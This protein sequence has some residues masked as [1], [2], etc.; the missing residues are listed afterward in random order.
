MTYLNLL[1]YKYS[2]I[3]ILLSILCLICFFLTLNILP[4]LDRDESRYIQSTV[5]MLES[6]D[7]V[8][9]NFLETP[10]LKKPPGVYW[11]QA[12]SATFIKNIF[13]LESPPLWSFRLPSAIG[14]GISV[15]LTFLLGQLLFSRAQGFLA[16]LLLV[17]S[18]L[19]IIESHIAKTDSALLAFFLFS[20]YILAK[21]IFYLEKKIKRPSD[22]TI[23][24]AWAALAFS[25]LIKGPIALLILLLL[26]LFFKLSRESI[27]F[28]NFKPISGIVIFMIIVLP[29]FLLI[30][31]GNNTDIF[32]NS[33][34]KDMILKLISV[35]ESHGAPPGFYILSSLITAWPITLFIFPTALWAYKNKKN[36]PVKFL[37]CSFIPAW[38]FFEIMPTK[39]LHYVLPLLPSFAIL[40]AAMIVSSIKDK[41]FII[42]FDKTIFKLISV[43]PF[44]GGIIIA[45]G[46]IY[47][48]NIYGEGLTFSI[49]IIAC[50]YILASFL[51]AY[52]LYIQSFMKGLI[53]VV[54]CNIIAL[55]LLIF[56][57]PNQ[58][59]KIWVSE[60]INFEIKK[61]NDNQQYILLGYSEP[62]LVYRLGSKTKIVSS[63]EEAIN[64]ILYNNIKSIIIENSYLEEFK[65][66]SNKKGIVFANISK[67]IAGF[68]Y[69]KGKNVEIII[70][71][72][73]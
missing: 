48:V 59:Q 21:I 31:S 41:K 63:S 12:M 20:L 54:F 49:L 17:S 1:D 45:S 33:I 58:L 3:K 27:N 69:S 68:N 50:I 11:L 4:P 52:F 10:R 39:L 8:N 37:L 14:A 23:I 53:I 67:S 43:L 30:Q 6:K 56:M 35:Q 40:T 66:L 28:K 18:P 64:L 36:K 44:L 60:R 42:L 5:Q 32:F 71:N 2:S 62:S 38:L 22:I 65:N 55:N 73:N 51:S 70:I 34:K 47:L 57:I 9:I 7:F 46:L 19:L 13:F 15:W 16:A 72:F 29:W 25:F 24:S 61:K 26:I